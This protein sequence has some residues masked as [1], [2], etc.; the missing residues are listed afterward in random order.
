MKSIAVLAVFGV[1]SLGACSTEVEP[2]RVDD[3]SIS[4]ESASDCASNIDLPC[5]NCVLCEAQVFSASELPSV[6]QR[7]DDANAS[8][9]AFQ[10]EETCG[11]CREEDLK[12]NV[13][14]RDDLCV[15]APGDG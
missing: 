6:S 4:C 1:L 14:C 2:I 7:L 9:P 3:L 8:C 11:P 12:R 15:A 5:S 10:L 13:E